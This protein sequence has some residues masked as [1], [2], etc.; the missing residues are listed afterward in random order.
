MKAFDR[1]LLSNPTMKLYCYCS[2]LSNREIF[3]K[4]RAFLAPSSLHNL[5]EDGGKE[6]SFWGKDMYHF[7]RTKLKSECHLL[8]HNL[9]QKF[10]NGTLKNQVWKLLWEHPHCFGLSA[11]LLI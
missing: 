4:L 1:D 3:F 7:Y 9:I 8:L 11:A 6:G 2:V 5:M 10:D